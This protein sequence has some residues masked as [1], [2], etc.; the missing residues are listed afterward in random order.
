VLND[1]TLT[2]FNVIEGYIV[3]LLGVVTSAHWLSN[4]YLKELTCFM[5]IFRPCKLVLKACCGSTTDKLCA[6]RA[7]GHAFNG[8]IKWTHRSSSCAMCIQQL[9][10]HCRIC[11]CCCSLVS[12]QFTHSN[13]SMALLERSAIGEGRFLSHQQQRPTQ[14]DQVRAFFCP[15]LFSPLSDHCRTQCCHTRCMHV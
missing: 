6:I 8:A 9:T 14:R 12:M 5:L 11:C 15:P 2:H 7:F 13:A 4:T 1:S 3:P 10:C